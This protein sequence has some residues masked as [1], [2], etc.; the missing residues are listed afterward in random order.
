VIPARTVRVDLPRESPAPRGYDV[1]I[2]PGLLAELG[3]RLA[4]LSRGR[5]A[6]L[7]VDEGLPDLVHEA[8]EG[9][10]RDAGFAVTTS[11]VFA[12][13]SNKTIDT[14]S[15]LLHEI[16]DTRHERADPVVALGGG[17]IGDIAGF[18][19]ATYRRGVPF[20]QCPTTLLAMV[21]ASIGGKTGVNLTLDASPTG[22]KKNMVGAFWQPTLVL[23]DIESLSS[24]PD[25]HL[26]SGLAECL[27]HGI[28]AAPADAGLFDWTRSTLPA[29]LAREP[30]ALSE[31]IERNVRIKA[32]IVAQDEREE[33]PSRA[34]G[35]ALLNLGHT[36]AHVLEPILG[37]SP[38][39]DP[40]LAPLQHGEAVA[41]GLVAAAAT[42][43]AM[44]RLAPDAEE[45]IRAAVRGLG[46][47]FPLPKLP[48]LDAL[49]A[50][51]LHDK[52]TAGSALRLV[53]PL[54]APA[55]GWGGAAVVENPPQTAVR[56]GW[57]ALSTP[58]V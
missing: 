29:F 9:S 25:R 28:I 52:K 10:L 27:K 18:V 41:L 48:P 26:R 37:L 19:A 57:L 35:R 34:G 51:M 32:A 30:A 53:L 24:L 56:A 31:L 47:E 22:T 38:T 54:S 1:V 6:F 4:S 43:R 42:A 16:A 11:R 36:F 14:A 55:G 21:D 2:G 50:A 5:R 39:R 49:M 7:V 8:A 44:S 12:A 23:T 15:R 46:I 20:V 17:V 13:E 33:L 58:H 45:A 40:E 3:P